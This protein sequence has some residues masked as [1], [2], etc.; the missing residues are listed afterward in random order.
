MST[1]PLGSIGAGA[2]GLPLAQVRAGDAER[3]KEKIDRDGSRAADIK[4]EKSAGVGETDGEDHET[5]ERDAD[6]RRPW[7][8]PPPPQESDSQGNEAMQGDLPPDPTG[9][10]GNLLD[11]SG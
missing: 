1:G 11:I 3:A 4:A 7:E 5:A 2:A 10:S 9:Q 8:E 6:G